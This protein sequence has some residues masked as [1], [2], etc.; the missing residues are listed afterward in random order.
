MRP[1]LTLDQVLKRGLTYRKL[2]WWTRRGWLRPVHAGGSGTSRVW[3]QPEL[4]IADLMRRLTRAGLAPEAAAEA[5]RACVEGQRLLVTIGPGLVL[6]ID[7]S[8]LS[9]A[10]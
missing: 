6:A 3:P 8:L 4:Q 1:A 5:A 7:T 9:E 2:D 10:S